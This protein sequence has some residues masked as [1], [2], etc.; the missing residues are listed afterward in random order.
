MNQKILL[1]IFL[2]NLIAAL[3]FNTANAQTTLL[4]ESFEGATFPPTGW[5][6]INAGSGPNSWE[7]IDD[8]GYAYHG[9]KSMV[10]IYDADFAANTWAFTPP[11]TLNT[12]PCYITFYVRVDLAT[13]PE[14]MKFTVGNAA[15]VAAQTTVLL[16]TANITNE[17]YR[18]WSA[19][20]TPSAAGN[21][22]FAFNCYSAADQDAL[23]IDSV[24]ITQ[25]LPGCTGTPSAGS[26]AGPAGA[27]TGQ[28]FILTS[29]GVSLG[30]GITYAWQRSANGTSGWT[31][32]AGQTSGSGATVSQTASTWYRLV[33]T[34][35]GNAAQSAISN[36]LNVPMTTVGCPPPN[37]QVCNAITLVLNGPADCQNTTNAAIT[38][39]DDPL[40]FSCSVTNNTTWYKY[41]PATTGPV[42]INL[43]VPA[44]DNLDGWLG[45]YQ[46]TSGS[47]PTGLTLA[48]S[49][50]VTL[51][52]CT[53]FGFVAN[54]ITTLTVTLQAGT[55][56]YFM[57]DGV[58]GAVGNYC[59]SIQTP[60]LPPACTTN[61]SP[62]NG[63]TNI[64]DP[65]TLTWNAAAGATSYTLYLG[66]TNP[67]VVPT[68]SIATVGTNSITVYG[69]DAN[70]TYYWYVIPKNGG[71]AATGCFANTS[72]FTTANPPA[73]DQCN[74]AVTLTVSNGFCSN[75]VL[76][77]LALSD[78]TTG[79]GTPSCQASALTY[80]VWYKAVVPA[81]GKITVQTSAVN[82]TTT[83][84]VLQAYS[85]NCGA[86]TAIGCDDDGNTDDGS[87][88]ALH[89]KLGLT[90]R[91]PG[92]TIYYRVMGYN[93]VLNLGAFAICAFDTTST[94]MPLVAAGTA[95]TC[96][97]AIAPVTIDSA[98]KYTWVTFKDASGNVIAQL[99]PNGNKLGSTTASFYRNSGTVRSDA[100]GI[101]YLDRN[102]TIT[103]TTQPT[104]N[105]LTRLFF[106]NTE[107]TALAAVAGATTRANLNT[108]KTSQ[109][110]PSSVSSGSLIIQDA[111]AAYGADH[112]ID[113]SNNSFS[114][115]FLHKGLTPIPI[116]LL[117]F[118][119]Q[120]NGKTNSI[121]WKTAQETN[122]S[123]FLVERSRNGVDFISIG[124]VTAAGNSATTLSYSLQ[125]LSPVR[126]NNY[127][128]LRTVDINSR[129]ELSMIRMVRNEGALDAS[130][131]P[132]P[133][134]D[135]LQLYVE[136][137]NSDKGTM[138]ITDISGKRVYSKAISIVAGSNKLPV[139]ITS[140]SSGTYIFKIQLT[141]EMLV[142][143]FNKQ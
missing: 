81:S 45:C 100:N 101:F 53:E 22:N 61:T 17:T 75:P 95:N 83:D 131:Y 105:V 86:L 62:V 60:P 68:D 90:G 25:V 44:T 57:I 140:L 113:I 19:V 71:G 106:K 85:G 1:K 6:V 119:A 132:N 124:R 127:Y 2:C 50:D 41:T 47:C 69:F 114:T 143:K 102:I 89:A 54:D 126:G 96:T 141:S 70:T 12:N 24:T 28:D 67:P 120:R 23:F 91:T 137:D 109:V 55:T 104:S 117:S 118:N 27:C 18:R 134:Q 32:I 10:Y 14:S 30:T 40:D 15:T 51:G 39:A 3:F 8:V 13:Y 72:S 46:A 76:G 110:C 66:T 115:F 103:P 99:F 5:T 74:N 108:T 142:R 92:E 59:I 112:S 78:S 20:Y 65:V 88:S 123:H 64:G 26:I 121:S 73:N 130:I 58:A 7:Q 138:I 93:T 52:G 37:D 84:L 97:N 80:D 125:D 77:T 94:V 31:N 128:R 4:A 42:Q 136:S 116:T 9:T 36:V 43:S 49:T 34:C 107:L 111:N 98:Y 135:L 82:T 21:Y 16:D 133:V 122:T 33:D 63:A 129:Q 87:P 79:L 11:V 56:Y 29:T 35:N 139:D 38:G 48:D